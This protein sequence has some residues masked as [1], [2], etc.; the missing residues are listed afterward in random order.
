MSNSP[1]SLTQ[2]WTAGFL[3]GQIQIKAQG[4][5]GGNSY[6]SNWEH[7]V[8][9]DQLWPGL[10]DSSS[11]L[12][13]VP[14]PELLLLYPCAMATTPGPSAWSMQQGPMAGE[15]DQQQWWQ[16]GWLVGCWGCVSCHLPHCCWLPRP[17]GHKGPGFC[18]RPCPQ[19]HP[20]T[21]AW[22]AELLC[23]TPLDLAIPTCSSYKIVQCF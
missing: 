10:H 3:E 9:A 18:N 4:N 2:V 19:P 14:M 7:A 21:P 16:A 20:L 11:G 17:P 15:T 8:A 1:W 13:C 12:H 23:L 22:P 6:S 5:S